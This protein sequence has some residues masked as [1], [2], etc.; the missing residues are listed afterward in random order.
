[1]H[2]LHERLLAATRLASVGTLAAG[3]AH[4]INNPLTWV[5]TNLHYVLEQLAEAPTAL[6]PEDLA[7][8]RKVVADA[9]QGASRIEAIVKAMRS[10]GGPE[11]TEEAHDINVRREPLDAI[12]MARN[13]VIQKAALRI[14]LPEDLPSARAKT[15][16][17]GRVFLN[18]LI[19][20]AQAIPDGEARRHTVSVRARSVTGEVEVEVSDTGTGISPAVRSRIFD[21]F[22]TTKPVGVGTGLG[23]S[24]A[25]SIVEGA[26]GRIDVETAEGRG[27]TFRVRLP[28]VAPVVTTV[29]AHEPGAVLPPKRR[30]VLVIDDEPLVAGSLRR[31]LSRVHDVT[32]L[33]SPPEALRLI[34]AGERFDAI[35]CDFMMP[36]MDGVAVYEALA[37][38]G[39]QLLRRLAFMTGGVFGDRTTGFLAEHDVVIVPKP[40]DMKALHMVVETLAS[41]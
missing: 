1:M 12:Q 14:D 35:L 41:S 5:S 37:A 29:R 38:R 24:I 40:I 11:R 21:P 13:Q 33:T 16:E 4:E 26:G 34:D 32:V 2:E 36:E 9:L 10:L 31:S 7:E 27:A 15:N 39:S 28:S 30:R 22:F 19:N 17:L 6:R 23:L 8:F 25:R 18:L 3:V 20:A